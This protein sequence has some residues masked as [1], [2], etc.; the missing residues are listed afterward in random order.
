MKITRKYYHILAVLVITMGFS[1]HS[2]AAEKEEF[3]AKDLRIAML[4]Q[5][6]G[7]ICSMRNRAI[8]DGVA[9]VDA[10][11]EAVDRSISTVKQLEELTDCKHLI[12]LLEDELARLG[13]K[14]LAPGHP[15]MRA[16][17]DKIDLLKASAKKEA[18]QVVPPNGP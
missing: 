3:S 9:P 10:K 13:S 16:L 14:G 1:V 5:T 2:I 7:D 18:E 11:K 4:L 17:S 8:T 12:K 6:L 15:V